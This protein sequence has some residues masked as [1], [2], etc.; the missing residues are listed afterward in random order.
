M[1]YDSRCRYIVLFSCNTWRKRIS[2]SFPRS[3]TYVFYR[4][5]IPNIHISI[6]A[7]RLPTPI[8]RPS[9]SDRCSK[10]TEGKEALGTP[11]GTL[12]RNVRN[13]PDCV[14]CAWH[15]KIAVGLTES[16]LGGRPFDS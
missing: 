2:A 10:A 14:T 7:T 13:A 11:H 15:Q 16:C 9:L 8:H 4:R 6:T 12:L 1:S 5:F 3:K